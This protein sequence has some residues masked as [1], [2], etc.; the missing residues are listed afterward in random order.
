[1]N[2]FGLAAWPAWFGLI[3]LAGTWGARKIEE[4]YERQNRA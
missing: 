4:H 3:C 1:M 2:L